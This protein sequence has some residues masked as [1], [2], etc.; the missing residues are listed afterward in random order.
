[1]KVHPENDAAVAASSLEP[2]AS[3]A[4]AVELIAPATKVA[5]SIGIVF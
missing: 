4:M 5:A 2:I 3:A 1:M